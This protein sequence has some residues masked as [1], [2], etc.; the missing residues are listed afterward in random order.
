FA[1]STLQPQDSEL[2]CTA[3]GWPSTIM[4][5]SPSTIGKAPLCRGQEAWSLTRATGT[6]SISVNDE[7]VMTLPPLLV[8]SPRTIQF[9]SMP[10]PWLSGSAGCPLRWATCNRHLTLAG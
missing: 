5:L 8:G 9:L 1:D 6:P 10:Y 4:V 2:P 7:P 3:T